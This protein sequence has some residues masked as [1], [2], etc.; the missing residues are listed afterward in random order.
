MTY[1]IQ[2][3]LLHV[4]PKTRPGT[5]ITVEGVVIHWTA[6][7]ASGADNDS[8][9]RYFNK[10]SVYASAHYFVDSK[11]ILRI[12]PEN[13]MAYH[14][15]AKT[16][17]TNKFG[18]YPN[19]KLIGIEMCVNS[20]GSFAET[21]KRAVWLTADIMRRHKLGMDTLVR[22]YD[23]TG[24]ACPL[25]FT[26]DT[27]AKKYLGMTAAQAHAKFRADVQALLTGKV[28]AP[29]KPVAVP[30]PGAMPSYLQK[31][32]KGT[33]VTGLQNNLIKAGMSMPKYGADGHYGQETV[34]AVKAFQKKHGLVADGIAGKATFD[35]LAEVLAP[36]KSTHIGTIKVL[37]DQLNVRKGPSFTA[38][39]ERVLLKNGVFKVYSEQNGLYNVGGG[40][41]VSAGTKY[42]KF[43]KL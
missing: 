21:Y 28:V 35:K 26:S 39:S 24:K 33:A 12:I 31:D 42:V 38:P 6:N 15:G 7:T 5:K 37:V 18:A 34:D 16:Y 10:G 43:T 14:V 3:K 29:V 1:S 8:H 36:K 23:V 19:G 9:Y 2:E 41:W 17:K 22:H 32:D 4:N 20:D 25:M 40:D 27:A 13:E 30:K 11:G